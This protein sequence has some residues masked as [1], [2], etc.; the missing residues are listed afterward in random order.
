MAEVLIEWEIPV[1]LKTITRRTVDQMPSDVV[2]VEPLQA[3]VQP[4]SKERLN[5]DRVDWSRRHIQVH[6][7]RELFDGQVIEYNGADYKII[8]DGNYQLYGFSDVVAES[9]D[10]PPLQAT[11]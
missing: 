6:A 4:A 5:A 3:V 2:V 11:P 8:E 10:R 1:L 9:T 7:R